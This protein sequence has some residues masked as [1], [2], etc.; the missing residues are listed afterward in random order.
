MDGKRIDILV[1]GIMAFLSAS[2]VPDDAETASTSGAHTRKLRW[3]R[4]SL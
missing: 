1:L 4:G 2:S 3:G